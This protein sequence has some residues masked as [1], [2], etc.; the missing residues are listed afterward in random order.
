MPLVNNSTSTF[1]KTR[2]RTLALL[3]AFALAGAMVLT[4]P[5]GSASAASSADVVNTHPGWAAASADRGALPST[6]TLTTTVYLAGQD[7][8]G[9]TAYATA[10]STPGS[11][12]FHKYLTPAQEQARFGATAAQVKAVTAWLTSA[13]LKVIG[14]DEHSITVQGSVAATQAAYGTSMHNYLIS[15]KTY[16]APASDA[17]VPASVASAVLTIDGL[18]NMPLKMV[19]NTVGQ[20]STPSVPGLSGTT[21]RQ[22][23][24]ADGSTFLGPT[25]CSSYYGQ[26]KDT[27]DPAINGV[28]DSPYAVCGYVPS[29]LRGAYGVTSTGLTGKGVT[30]AITDAYGSDTIKADADQYAVNHGDKAF[31]SGQFTETVTPSQWTDLSACGGQAG[32]AP[33]ESLDVEAVHAMAPG[34]DIHYYGSNSCN[35]ADFLAVFTSIVDTHSADVVSNSWEGV[36]YSSTGNEPPASIAEYSALFTQGAIEGIG[37]DFS[38]GD[39]GAEDPATACGTADTSTTPQPDFPGSDPWVTDVG[40]TSVAIGKQNQQEWNT[41]W[42][43]DAWVEETA[44]SWTPFGWQFGGGG[45]TSAYF[46][47]PWYQRGVVSKTLA[48]TLPDGSTID[49]PDRVAPDVSMDADPYTGFLF[50]MTQTLPDGSTGYAESDIGGTSLAAPLFTG[51]QA[52]AVQAQGAAIGFADPSLYSRY[53]SPALSIV[54]AHNAG[55]KAYNILPP[56]NGFPSVAVNFGDDQ[57]LKATDKYSDAN[58]L[59]TATPW[60][61]WSFAE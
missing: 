46:A 42:G 15:G 28:S 56:F 44:G 41:V 38:S 17:Q 49:S 40:G 33:E 39:C 31:K 61:L 57:L 30:V 21:A 36:I 53:Q 59:G 32:W 24:G 58:G 9:M 48:T 43:T 37:F 5:A 27:T 6:T 35:D 55:T 54:T 22:S 34:A 19:T 45:G 1:V 3:P 50:G 16:Y 23:I 47:Q 14:S 13:G 4:G 26:I 2:S 51:L 29:Q 18:T 20:V 25:P 52:D 8:A 11:S 7:P 10:V 12:L 60:Y